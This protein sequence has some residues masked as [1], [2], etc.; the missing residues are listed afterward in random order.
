MLNRNNNFTIFFFNSF[1]FW[2]DV[3]HTLSTDRT[4]RFPRHKRKKKKFRHDSRQ[5]TVL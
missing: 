1:F 2:T 5:W 3:H 4:V